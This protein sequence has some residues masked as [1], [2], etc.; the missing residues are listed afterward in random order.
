VK[1]EKFLREENSFAR[2]RAVSLRVGP[3]C[4]RSKNRKATIGGRELNLNWLFLCGRFVRKGDLRRL[5][6]P[7]LFDR[8]L[9][10][11]RRR[12][13]NSDWRHNCWTLC[14]GVFG[15]IVH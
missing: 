13:T 5:Y 10:G 1:F 12:A 4:Y 9:S 7:S 14:R 2:L 11:C 6:D 15:R 8:R 3:G